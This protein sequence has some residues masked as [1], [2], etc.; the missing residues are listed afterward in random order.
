MENFS[1][2]EVIELAVQIEKSGYGFYATALERKDLSEKARE[3]IDHLRIE[4]IQHEV[5]FKNLRTSLDYEKLGD[6]IDWQLA[7]SYL[8]TIS[9][10]HV[11][12]DPGASIKLATTATDEKEIIDFAI[13]F[14]KDTL[15]FFHSLNHKTTDE[16]TKE[17]ITKIID[18][19]ISHVVALTKIRKEL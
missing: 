2:N 4:E 7:A 8:K 16:S 9:D 18:E 6:P 3:L 5:T 1:L 14:E 10:S 12:S 15:L 17:I 11:F 19:E 13:H